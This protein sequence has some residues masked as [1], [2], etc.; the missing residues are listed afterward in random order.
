MGIFL[1]SDTHF[2]HARILELC[3]RPFSSTEEMNEALITNYNKVVSPMDTVYHLGDVA[4]GKIAESLPLLNRMNGAK[5]LVLGNHDRP[6]PC[7]HHKND[8]KRAEWFHTYRAYFPLIVP[9]IELPLGPNQETV[10]L[11]H[12]PYADPTYID[13]A[14][15]GRHAEFQPEDAGLWLLHGH[16]HDKWRV[17]GR[18]INVGVDVWGYAPV[19]LETLQELMRDQPK[20]D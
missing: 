5:I 7:Y 3:N 18:Q 9:G 15:E 14:F 20:G 12:F 2:G 17:K 13:H 10:L 6:S 4:M 11:H 8:E 1:T 16:V 19:S